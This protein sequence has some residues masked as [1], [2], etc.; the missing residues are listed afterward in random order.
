M[1]LRG[2]FLSLALLVASPQAGLALQLGDS[3]Q[4]IEARYDTAPIGDHPKGIAIYRWDL[5]KL[6]IRYTDDAARTLVYTKLD[7]IPDTEIAALL[8]Q[9][10][11]ISHWHAV[12]SAQGRAV[13]WQRVDGASAALDATGRVFTLQ[14][15]K[16]PA[17]VLTDKAALAQSPPEAG[18]PG[19]GA[20]IAPKLKTPAGSPAPAVSRP[21]GAPKG[22]APVNI[23]P[24]NLGLAVLRAALHQKMV[25]FGALL[26]AAGAALQFM[27]KRQQ[28]AVPAPAPFPGRQ[29]IPGPPALE[30]VPTLENMSPQRFELLMGEVFRRKGYEVEIPAADGPDGGADLS[31]RKDGA[32]VLAQCKHY[33]S[34]SVGVQ[35]IREFYGVITHERAAR[36][37]FVNTSVYTQD[38]LK[39]AEGKEIDLLDGDA[40]AALINSVTQPGENIYDIQQWMPGFLAHAVIKHPACPYCEKP[41]VL[42]PSPKGGNFWGCAGFP[43]CNGT[44]D[45]RADLVKDMAPKAGEPGGCPTMA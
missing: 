5:W 9:N 14:G 13:G 39:F 44:R 30:I 8:D 31:L 10:G 40:V 19:Q 23:A 16:L 24:P 36:G 42:R 26:I 35:F 37:I 34:G 18:M 17:A 4:E 15:G 1:I 20:A 7:P 33:R 32:L 25:W 3:R 28:A 45:A 43:Q 29:A 41:M 12:S 2:F 22:A 38:A 11:G 21:A 27:K 6:E